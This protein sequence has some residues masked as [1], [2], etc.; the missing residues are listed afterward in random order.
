MVF[1]LFLLAC[2]VAVIWFDVT[3][4]LIPNWLNG[5]ILAAYPLA[6]FMAPAGV[7]WKNAL[8]GMVIVFVLGYIMFALKWMG[9]GDV[10]LITVLSLWVG[11]QSLA[12]FIF[13]FAIIGGVFSIALLVGRKII[14]HV[15]KS[16]KPLPRLLRPGEPVAYGLAIA[17][18]FLILMYKGMIPVL[19]VAA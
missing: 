4:Y 8:L 17:L 14:P 1:T 3:R 9:G 6:V 5:L 10:K 7:D 2:M 19:G 18:G 11:F 12:Q 13:L 15:N 16:G